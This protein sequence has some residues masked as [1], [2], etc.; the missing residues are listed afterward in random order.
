MCVSE[1]KN[2]VLSQQSLE[3]Q[4]Y[5]ANSEQTKKGHGKKEHQLSD[6]HTTFLLN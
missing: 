1:K 3:S 5:L 6:F 4:C 2:P